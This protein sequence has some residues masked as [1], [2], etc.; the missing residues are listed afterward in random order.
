MP[1]AGQLE[2]R[3]RATS[4][5][6]SRCEIVFHCAPSEP[7]IVGPMPGVSDG[8]TTAAPAPSPKMNAEPRSVAVGEVGELLD[9][10]DEDVLG[11][12]RRGPCRWPG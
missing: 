2:A 9:A 12:C 1:I 8:P 10:D 5:H 4:T 11:R 7:Q 6:E 3:R